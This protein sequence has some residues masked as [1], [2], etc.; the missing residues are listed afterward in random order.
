MCIC[1]YRCKTFNKTRYRGGK[2]V[3][4]IDICW[5]DCKRI[6][7]IGSNWTK[8]KN[9]ALT[10]KPH[11][12]N[13]RGALWNFYTHSWKILSMLIKTVKIVLR[14]DVIL[15]CCCS[16][17][18]KLEKCSFE[19]TGNSGSILFST[20]NHSIHSEHL[21]SLFFTLTTSQP[22]QC[23]CYFIS[24]HSHSFERQKKYCSSSNISGIKRTFYFSQIFNWNFSNRQSLH[25]SSFLKCLGQMISYD[26]QWKL[27][28]HTKVK[29][30][31]RFFLEKSPIWQ[32]CTKMNVKIISTASRPVK[33]KRIEWICLFLSNVSILFIFSCIIVRIFAFFF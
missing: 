15:F 24:E 22:F 20:W 8:M 31:E 25:W 30:R 29:E 32:D 13:N 19:I 14:W 17:I 18:L 3:L 6:T 2:N 10:R 28:E 21:H 23:V 9:N 5:V 4:I 12:A 26:N 11:N 33:T 1:Y 16:F 27:V 7:L